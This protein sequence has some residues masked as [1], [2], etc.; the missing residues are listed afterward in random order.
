MTIRAPGRTAL[1]PTASQCR[2]LSLTAHLEGPE[3]RRAGPRVRPQLV[4]G[5]PLRLLGQHSAERPPPARAHRLARRAHAPLAPVAERVLHEAVLARMIADHAPP[6]APLP[7]RAQRR[8]R[9]PALP[10][11]LALHDTPTPESA[12]DSGPGR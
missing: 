3:P 12:R 5:R 4:R 6:A 8:E 1:S 11:V 2:P 10:P 7:R 9:Q